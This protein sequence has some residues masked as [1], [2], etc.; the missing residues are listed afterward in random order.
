MIAEFLKFAF[1]LSLY[2]KSQM[3][4]EV[5]F[6][7]CL[8]TNVMISEVIDCSYNLVVNVNR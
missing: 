2:M 8:L 1:Q 6:Y 4:T 7:F 5:K 3:W